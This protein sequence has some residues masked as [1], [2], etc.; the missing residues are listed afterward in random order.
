ML[1]PRAG[2]FV[3]DLSSSVRDRL[4]ERVGREK[5]A[6]SCVL[7]TAAHNEQG[8]EMR[9]GGDPALEL[10]DVDGLALVRRPLR[11]SDRPEDAGP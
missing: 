5:R 6:G 1:Q 4:W 11:P 3:G 9:C 10:I 7:I 2:V 8:F